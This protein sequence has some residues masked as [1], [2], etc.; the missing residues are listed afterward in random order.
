MFKHLKNILT[1][2]SFTFL[3]LSTFAGNAIAK[4]PDM[5]DP[6][7]GKGKGIL[8]TVQ[9]YAYDYVIFGGLILGVIA[10]FFVAIS[11]FSTYVEIQNGKKKWSDLATTAVIG[12]LLI[13]IIL[14]LVNQ[15]NDIL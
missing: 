2:I 13:V 12:A 5:G 9:N 11:T 15:A 3:G 10:F 14:W 8:D 6:S 4:L 7:R 1:K